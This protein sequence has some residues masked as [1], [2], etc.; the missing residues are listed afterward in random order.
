MLLLLLLLQD[1]RPLCH[2][3]PPCK[4]AVAGRTVVLGCL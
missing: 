4:T 2:F 1:S 3:Q